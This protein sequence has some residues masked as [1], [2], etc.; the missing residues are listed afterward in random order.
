MSSI[1][2]IVKKHHNVSTFL[3]KTYSEKYSSQIV[4]VAF[5][6]LNTW[7]GFAEKRAWKYV[8]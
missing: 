7:P 6:K 5:L 8:L 4:F 3:E 2:V 1:L